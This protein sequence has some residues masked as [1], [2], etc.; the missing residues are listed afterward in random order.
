MTR[1]GKPGWFCE[2]K[3]PCLADA[4]RGSTT[5][6]IYSMQTVSQV[7]DMLCTAGMIGHTT[8]R[9]MLWWDVIECTSNSNKSNHNN[10]SNDNNTKLVMR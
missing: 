1:G 3:E 5:H 8:W 6:A 7:P 9:A 4:G 2:R 10:N